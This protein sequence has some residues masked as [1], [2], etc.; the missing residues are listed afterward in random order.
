MAK[1]DC[2]SEG[3]R[4]LQGYRLFHHCMRMIFECLI[5]AGKKGVEMV[6]ADGWI[7]LVFLILAAYVADF[8]EQCLVGCCME[9]RCPQ[10]TVNP[11]DR[12]SP[13]ECRL[14]DM[15]ETLELLTKH[16]QGRDPPQ[17]ERIGLRAV[18]E[19]F[20]ADLP[21]CDIFRSFTSDILHQLH[22]GVFKDHLV[23]WCTQIMGGKELDKRFKA[24]NSYPG[25]RHFKKGITS[26]SQWTG[27]EHKEMEKVL[28]G[29]TIGAVPSRF[30][31][32]VRSL[33][34][35]IYL[36]QLQYH[37]S[38]TIQSMGTCLKTFH[39]NKEI[40]IELNIREHFNIPKVHA[41]IHYVDCIELFGSADGYN[42]ESPERLHID[43]AKEAYRASNKR[44]YVEQMAIWL[45]RHEAMW[46]RESF[47]IWVGKR[48]EGLMKTTDVSTDST[49]D[50]DEEDAQVELELEHVEVTQRDINITHD[51]PRDKLNLNN[52]MYSLAKSPPHHNLTV[53][54]L[55]E[56]FGTSYF[57]TSLSS[58]LRRNLPG[59]T[60]TPTT[61]DRFDAYKQIIISLPANQY[62]CE[63][64]VVDRIRTS[65]SVKASGRALAKA[66]HFDTAFVAEDLSLY[67]S[68]GG[69]SGE[70]FFL[71]NIGLNLTFFSF[72]VGLRVAQIRLIFNLP[73]QFG[74]YH[75]PLA[76]IEWFT[77][78]GNMD[79]VTGLH[80]VSRSTRQGQRNAEIVSVDRIVR[81]C[82]LMARCGQNISSSL[83]T[84]NVLEQTSVQY[85]VNPYITVDSFTLLKPNLFSE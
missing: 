63:R 3:T 42:T 58:F 72:F 21:H 32:V 64:V 5:E 31:R 56:K 30:I 8:P 79:P 7:R 46:L 85:L 53:E 83:T 37:T 17:F 57:L 60:I 68:Q 15:K 11:K 66:A 24:M 70:F 65:P 35:F 54:S 84:D 59:T 77:Q 50:E 80:S 25:L 44:D 71:S 29:I 23:A 69:L 33:L 4:S 73:P 76:Y 14:R 61:C 55:S 74:S 78:L 9:N 13:V 39:D 81:G 82:H 48:L 16:Q 47:L 27:T 22:K 1:L 18:Y 19:P 43:F 52:F 10:C 49:M 12:G 45:Q 6:C 28:L 62:Q 67:E 51:D 20:W 40:I 38:T 41:L 34:D 36:S 26:V 2:Y 75:H